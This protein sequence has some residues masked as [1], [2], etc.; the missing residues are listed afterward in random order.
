MASYKI[1]LTVFKENL[2]E[3][4]TNERILKLY[5]EIPASTKGQLTKKY[6]EHFKTSVV[7]KKKKGNL[8]NYLLII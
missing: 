7:H 5:K 2:I 1:G 6:G 3:L 8:F 4:Q